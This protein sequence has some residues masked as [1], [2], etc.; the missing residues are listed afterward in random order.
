[1][2]KKTTKKYDENQP[3]GK[4]VRVS[5]ILPAPNDL[6]L[7]DDTVKVTLALTKSS[8][9]FFKKEA[10]KNRTK[11]QRMIR[12]IIDRYAKEYS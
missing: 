5:D 7:S 6:V 2:K 8:L 10:K 4:L 12:E 3:V 11:Y 9:E 1:M